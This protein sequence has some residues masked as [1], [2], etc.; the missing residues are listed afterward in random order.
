M[1]LHL[2]HGHEGVVYCVVF[3]EVAGKRIVTGGADAFVRIWDP[4][5]S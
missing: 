2:L 1:C 5:T 3:A 4:E